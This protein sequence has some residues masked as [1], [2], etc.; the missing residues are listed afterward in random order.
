M[1]S[2]V[3]PCHFKSREMQTRV[4][5]GWNA[6]WSLQFNQNANANGEGMDG[7]CEWRGEGRVVRM[8]KGWSNGACVK[9]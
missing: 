8:E 4:E 7:W 6:R 9:P 3:W 1:R 2:F 5:R